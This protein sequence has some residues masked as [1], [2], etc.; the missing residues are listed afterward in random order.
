MSPDP[1]TLVWYACYG[2]N[3]SR[4][5]FLVYLDGGLAE[6]SADHHDGA[7]D[8]SPPRADGPAVFDTNVCFA[9][10]SGRWGGAPAFLEHRRADA[11]AL[12]RRYLITLEQFADVQAQENRRRPGELDLPADIGALAPGERRTVL[13]SAYGA[14][15]ALAPVDGHPTLTFT[16]PEPPEHRDPAPPSEMYLATILH[17]LREV[18][19]LDP[20]TLVERVGRSIGV[21]PH[22]SDDAMRDMLRKGVELFARRILRRLGPLGPLSAIARSLEVYAL[23]HLLDRYLGEVRQLR[24]HRI[25]E[26]EAQRVRAAIDAAVVRAIY[27]S[28][29]PNPL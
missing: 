5:R 11:G 18:H 4:D 14:V 3:C 10:H 27:P 29:K 1:E 20:D 19:D 23:G 12:G 22:W 7:R 15:A 9:G 17:G 8:P 28:V 13:D 26:P 6:G 24:S 2:S 21:R 25:L 16:A